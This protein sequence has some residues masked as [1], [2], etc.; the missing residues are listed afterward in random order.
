MCNSSWKDNEACRCRIV[1]S[2]APFFQTRFGHHG[3][4]LPWAQNT[5]LCSEIVT[6]YQHRTKQ[7]E[8]RQQSK[9]FSR[10]KHITV[11]WKHI[12]TW[13]YFFI[14]LHF[15]THVG[16]SKIPTV[17]LSILSKEKPQSFSFSFL[18]TVKLPLYC[19]V[20]KKPTPGIA[21]VFQIYLCRKEL[22][23]VNTK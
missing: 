10:E 18:V 21:M 1:I 5:D 16:C 12:V 6:E 11:S 23:W 22:V 19:V 3:N 15:P 7:R 17:L 20:S 4:G 2:T 14:R 13:G 8:I 9:I